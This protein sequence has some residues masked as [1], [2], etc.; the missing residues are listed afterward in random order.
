MSSNLGVTY[1]DKEYTDL[2]LGDKLWVITPLFLKNI[3]KKDNL[4]DKK[5]VDGIINC[6]NESGVVMF[7]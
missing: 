4:K 2:E 7:K 5:F 6:C 3:F 1:P